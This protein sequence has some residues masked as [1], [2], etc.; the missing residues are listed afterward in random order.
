MRMNANKDRFGRSRVGIIHAP[1]K[2][3]KCNVFPSLDR[4]CTK[5]LI[6]PE[7]DED[8]SYS[9]RRFD[10]VRCRGCSAAFQ[11]WVRFIGNVLNIKNKLASFS[12]FCSDLGPS[13]S[14]NKGDC[15][16]GSQKAA[17]RIVAH[18]VH[19]QGRRELVRS[20]LDS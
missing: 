2:I 5:F 4:P 19:V 15:E 9:S 13:T 8:D 3:Q 7:Y 14:A 6:A 20:R 1:V 17:R 16:Y 12:Q 18:L 11:K 10:G